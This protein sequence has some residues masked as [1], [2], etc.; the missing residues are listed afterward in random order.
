MLNVTKKKDTVKLIEHSI[1]NNIPIVLTSETENEDIIHIA[2]EYGYMYL[3]PVPIAA[4]AVDIS[5]FLG[6][7]EYANS[8][9]NE[10]PLIE[11]GQ[12]VQ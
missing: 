4:D 11:K 5:K 1:I 9:I 8:T 7:S 6:D 12:N 2:E 3:M 10:D